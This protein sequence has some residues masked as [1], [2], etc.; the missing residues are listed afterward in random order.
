MF[1]KKN[2][3]KNFILF[4]ALSLN[5]SVYSQ[6]ELIQLNQ[7]FNTQSIY[8]EDSVFYNELDIDSD[9]KKD[10]RITSWFGHSF[11]ENGVIEILCLDQEY[12]SGIETTQC[13]Y[14]QNC[15]SEIFNYEEVSGYLYT[16]NPDA[17][18]TPYIGNVVLPFKFKGNQGI[19]GGVFY[20]EYAENI[21]TIES[22][23]WNRSVG[24]NYNCNSN[25]FIE[26]LSLNSNESFRYYNLL[27]Q[28][29]F[30]LKGLLIQ[31]SSQGKSKK[32]YFN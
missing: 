12:L 28:E 21:I 22:I 11:G 26:D 14:L 31:I 19:Y 24:Q 25:L 32:V 16:T 8:P 4:L 5:F 20:V 7:V 18:E 2:D 15:N 10:I 6:V 27:G 17:C 3:M 13:G 30:D 29:V 9:G 23:G 1:D